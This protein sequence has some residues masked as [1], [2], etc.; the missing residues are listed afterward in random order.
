M[1]ILSA[2]PMHKKPL[3]LFVMTLLSLFVFAPT[4]ASASSSLELAMEAAAKARKVPLSLLQAIAYVNTRWEP[5]SPPAADGGFGPMN[6][7]PSQVDQA[8]ALSGHTPIQIRTDP[9]AN[10]DAGA[11]LLASAHTGAADLGSWQPAVAA[12]LGPFVAVEVY[13]DLRSGE[14]RTNG[15]GETIT[16]A[17]QAVPASTTAPAANSATGTATA[18]AASPDYPPAAW[19][20]ASTANFSTANRPHDYPVD[21]IIIHD[22]EGSY[23]SAIQEFQNPA[24]QVSAHYVISD[25][26]Q[27]TQM[28]AEHD[29]AWHAGN[30]DYNTRAIGI[31]HEGFAT[32]PNWY[33]TPMYDAS[34]HLIAS[35]CSRWG[36]PIDRTHVIGHYQ[37]PDPNHPGQFGG[38]GHHTDPGTNWDWTDYMSL[39][40]RYASAVPSPPHM[41]TDPVAV[42]LG[43]SATVSW[44]SAR[45]C[46]LPIQSYTVVSQ[47]GNIV[48]NLPAG[49][50]S[51]TFSGLQSGTSYTFT[52]TAH[53]AAGQDS[54]TSNPVLAGVQ[55]RLGGPIGSGPSVSSWGSNRMDAFYRGTNCQLYHQTWNGAGWS[56]AEALGG[57]LTAAPAAVSWGPNR[58]DVFVRGTDTALYHIAWLGSNWGNWEFLGGRLIAA[59]A[60]ASWSLNRLDVF[61]VGTDSA[62]YHR[63]WLGSGWSSWDGFGGR[64]TSTPAAISWGPNR[65]DV[66]ARGTDNALY[67]IAWLGSVWSGWEGLG[68]S[69]AGSAAVSSWQADRLDLFALTSAQTFQHKSWNGSSWSPWEELGHTQWL[70]DPAALARSA[71]LVDIFAVGTD[72]APWH[73]VSR[74]S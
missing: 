27:V 18:A 17:P 58:I 73:V 66:F 60:V 5:G 72:L 47:P 28:V 44:L 50:T 59:P 37:V 56:S 40:Q 42:E 51:T 36:V 63:A 6:I 39:A 24:A 25:A 8:A 7:L 70:D 11:A 3:A 45:S 32:G 14:S 4:T 35:I 29:I 48:Q 16:L 69:L 38:A 22:I 1:V 19:V 2:D 15:G 23:G 41:A 53:N 20:P 68:G 67:H 30:W 55:E 34:A 43:T 71:G 52:V 74:P 26:G 31:E 12:I 9:A 57:C 62:L 33:T 49:A 21:M 65:I 61:V 10:L 54:S 13:D 64:L 46:T